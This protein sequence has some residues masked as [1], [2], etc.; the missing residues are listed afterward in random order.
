MPHKQ[1]HRGARNK[2]SLIFDGQWIPTLREAVY[3]FSFLLTRGYS[4]EAIIK[5]VGDRYQLNQRQRMSVMRCAC[6]DQSLA[7]RKEHEM[8]LDQ[9]KDNLLAIDGFNLLIT[10]E[11][12]LSGGYIFEGRE[13]CYRDLASIHSTYKRVEETL[14]ALQLIGKFLE[15]HHISQVLWYLDKP[16]SNSGRLKTYIQ[17][18]ADHH[19]WNWTV[20]LA[21]DPDKALKVNHDIVVSNDGVI[22]DGCRSWVNLAK[23]L[24]DEK[25]T[26]HQLVRLGA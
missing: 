21:Y 26:K 4:E 17:E 23:N 15:V 5:M 2:D 19:Q 20:Y 7:C 3:D 25:I 14:S 22:L 9:V 10:I 6:S 8:A 11:S 18:I 12:A 16:V 13:G 1:K 24:I